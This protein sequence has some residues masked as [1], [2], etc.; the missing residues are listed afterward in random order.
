MPQKRAG[1]NRF[2]GA[3]RPRRVH[4]FGATD[5][6]RHGKSTRERFAQTND[7]RHHSTVLA[8]EPRAGAAK[9]GVNLIE[10]QQRAV[11]IANA[12]QHREKI[13][14]RNVD[15]ASRLNRLDKNGAEFAFEIFNLRLECRV[16]T[17][18]R[19]ELRELSKLG[20]KRTAIMFAMRGIERAI[21]QP[22]I[23]ALERDDAALAR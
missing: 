19:N 5:T 8:R 10:N 21:A 4:H 3:R 2:T 22:M 1:V 6:G 20:S 18:E 16:R 7:V 14:Q 11:L 12:P 17:T 9:P 23:R 13:R 15:A